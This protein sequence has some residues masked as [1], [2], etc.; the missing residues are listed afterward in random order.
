MLQL[1]E[2]MLK[3]L[4]KYWKQNDDGLQLEDFVQLMLKRIYTYDDD[5]KYELAYGSYKLF[6]EIDINGDGLM[7]WTEFMQFIIDA[8]SANTI[9]GG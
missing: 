5:E 6:M 2:K 3:S 8:V 9:T 1:S 7:E 4:E